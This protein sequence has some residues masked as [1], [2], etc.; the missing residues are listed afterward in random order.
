MLGLK[1]ASNRTRKI[2]KTW[3]ADT[4][5]AGHQQ[6]SVK[7]IRNLLRPKNRWVKAAYLHGGPV[8]ANRAHVL[9]ADLRVAVV[10]HSMTARH[11]IGAQLCH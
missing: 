6:G 8:A 10:A 9:R 2:H 7:T 3:H 1:A 11:Y 5:E 4:V